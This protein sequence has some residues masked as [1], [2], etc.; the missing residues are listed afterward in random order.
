MVQLAIGTKRKVT[1]MVNQCPIKLVEL[2]TLVNVNVLPLIS[3]D[4][5]VRM[6]WIEDHRAK[7]GCFNK[8]VTCLNEQGIKI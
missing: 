5:L 4:M 6:D 3:Y 8:R 2:N 7:V 1:K